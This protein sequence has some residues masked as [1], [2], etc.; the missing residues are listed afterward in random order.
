MSRRYPACAHRVRDPKP[1]TWVPL[2][3]ATCLPACAPTDQAPEVEVEVVEPGA[4]P[5]DLLPEAHL[6]ELGSLGREGLPFRVGWAWTVAP[7]TDTSFVALVREPGAEAS[8]IAHVTLGGRILSWVAG[9]EELATWVRGRVPNFGVAEDTVWIFSVDPPNHL[10]ILRSLHGEDLGRRM[11]PADV[12]SVFQQGATEFVAGLVAGGSSFVNTS[13]SLPPLPRS[14]FPLPAVL[15]EP[16]RGTPADTLFRG[17]D[18][19]PGLAGGFFTRAGL[20]GVSFEPFGHPPLHHLAPTGDRL[21]VVNW[22]EDDP[23]E[24][25][26]R[27]WSFP[28]G[29]TRVMH[30]P[31][32]RLRM[33]EDHRSRALEEGVRLLDEMESRRQRRSPTLPPLRTG[34][35]ALQDYVLFPPF[36]P[37]VRAVHSGEDGTIWL[38]RDE[39]AP[40]YLGGEFQ[41]SGTVTWIALDSDG[42]PLFRVSLPEQSRLVMASRSEI[43]TISLDDF[44]FV[45]WGVE[46]ASPESDLDPGQ[47][48]DSLARERA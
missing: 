36:M 22:D 21:V 17:G 18:T 25:E 37:S 5:F 23:A 47:P 41:E 19:H 4:H 15:V 27:V 16:A 14:V 46:G 6:E 7:I 31:L 26:I 43:W 42:V 48:D 20:F 2:L 24:L 38:L 32:P 10:L 33:T 1:R 40:L 35:E 13:P 29:Q 12:R 11:A 30:V 3:L 8:G 45:R 34:V 28:S 9:P 39:P 44:R